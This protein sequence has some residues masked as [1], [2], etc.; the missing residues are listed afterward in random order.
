MPPAGCARMYS[1]H[2]AVACGWEITTSICSSGSSS[3]AI[4]HCSTPST[5]SPTMR[6]S[7]ASNTS[8]SSV[9]LTEPSSEFSIGTTARST[10]PSRTA[11]TVSWIVSWAISSN[12]CRERGAQ[13]RGLGEGPFGTQ[14]A[15]THRQLSSPSRPAGP[16]RRR[17]GPVQREP[18]RLALL[19]RELELR[20]AVAD[21]LG[22]QPRGVAMVDRGEHDAGAG[23]VEQR[24]RGRLPPRHLAVGVVADQRAV[25][26]GCHPDA[27]RH[28]PCAGRAGS[29]SPPRTVPAN[30]TR[31]AGAPRVRRGRASCRRAP[32]AVPPCSLRIATVSADRPTDRNHRDRPGRDRDDPRGGVE[33]VHARNISRGARQRGPRRGQLKIDRV[34]DALLARFVSPGTLSTRA[35]TE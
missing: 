8:A 33:I 3:C 29:R 35:V 7:S 34:G 1:R 31:T 30:R 12:S 14:V 27:S 15:D 18:H 20:L 4:R 25:G 13:R 23:R 21:L 22:V 6:T 32:R 11:S 5:V 16:A 24:D 10:V 2:C 28:G 9:T 19:G 17:R 26:D